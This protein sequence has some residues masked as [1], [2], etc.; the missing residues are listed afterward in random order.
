VTG[1]THDALVLG[2][3]AMVGFVAAG[4]IASFYQWVTSEPA[5]FALLGTGMF[6][7]MVTFAFCA[8]TGPIIMLDKAVCFRRS[9]QGPVGWIFAGLFFALLWSLCSGIFVLGTILALRDSMA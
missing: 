2:Y 1:L 7:M 8:F 3:A 4:I 6:A 9:A 5:N